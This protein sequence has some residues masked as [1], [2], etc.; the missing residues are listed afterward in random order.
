MISKRNSSTSSCEMPKRVPEKR[1]KPIHLAMIRSYC[2]FTKPDA[3]WYSNVA[4]ENNH[5]S[6]GKLG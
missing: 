2:Q 3:L 5:V 1:N 6:Q 4:M